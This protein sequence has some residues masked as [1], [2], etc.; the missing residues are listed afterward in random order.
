MSQIIGMAKRLQEA[1][2]T[3]VELKK[4]LAEQVASVSEKSPTPGA[5]SHTPTVAP[6]SVSEHRIA[7][8]RPAY[9]LSHSSSNPS[10]ESTTQELLSDLSLDA[11]GKVVLLETSNRP[12]A[13]GSLTSRYVTMDQHLQYTIPRRSLADRRNFQALMS[14]I[15][16][17]TYIRC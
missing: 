1:E 10:R 7:I 2:A 8:P 3:I 13:R 11:S 14:K 12:E 6:H 17:S 16:K 5:G 15:R 4:A 9:S